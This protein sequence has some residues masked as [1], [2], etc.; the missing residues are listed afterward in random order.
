VRR[1]ILQFGQAMPAVRGREVC[2]DSS[3][4]CG[5]GRKEGRGQ[6]IMSRL[7]RSLRASG[8]DDRCA[9]ACIVLD[10]Y[11]LLSDWRG[12]VLNRVPIAYLNPQLLKMRVLA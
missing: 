10:A 1:H 8:Y 11:P 9:K 12:R 3:C 7:D 4:A 5:V 2:E 6:A